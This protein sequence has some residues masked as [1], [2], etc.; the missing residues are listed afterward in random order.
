MMV[1]MEVAMAILTA[2]WLST[3]RLVRIQVMKGTSTMPPPTPSRPAM[4]PPSR[5]SMASW[6]IVSVRESWREL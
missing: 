5:P 3:P 1:A 4:K 6:A 2:S